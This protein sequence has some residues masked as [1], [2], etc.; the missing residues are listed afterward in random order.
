MYC[1]AA[2]QLS[3]VACTA[4]SSRVCCRLL[5]TGS[6]EHKMV[7]CCALT[8]GR[9]ELQFMHL[10]CQCLRVVGSSCYLEHLLSTEVLQYRSRQDF[11][12][13]LAVAHWSWDSCSSNWR[14]SAGSGAVVLLPPVLLLLSVGVTVDKD[15]RRDQSRSSP[16][17]DRMK[18]DGY[19]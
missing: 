13:R 4:D 15:S 7:F 12:Q 14:P 17:P 3:S 18:L 9:Y 16:L 6:S 2:R 1:T 8:S 5:C 19:L 10:A 11:D